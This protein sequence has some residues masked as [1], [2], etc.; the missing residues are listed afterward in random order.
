MDFIKGRDQTKTISSRMDRAS[1]TETVKLDFDS[2]SGQTKACKIGFHSFP[3]RRSAIDRGSVNP[4]MCVVHKAL[5]RA[6]A[7]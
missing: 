5:S 7:A 2:R 6:A 3:A 4:P 1:A